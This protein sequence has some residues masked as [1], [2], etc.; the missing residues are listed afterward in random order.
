M[1]VGNLI[2]E[3]KS[4]TNF[5]DTLK[6]A[7]GSYGTN[8]IGQ[9][10]KLG[11]LKPLVHTYSQSFSENLQKGVEKAFNKVADRA[12]H[13]AVDYQ[14]NWHTKTVA[15][16]GESQRKDTYYSSNAYY[17]TLR[18][19]IYH[20]FSGLDTSNENAMKTDFENRLG[21]FASLT[22]VLDKAC[23]DNATARYVSDLRTLFNKVSEDASSYKKI[24]K[25]SVLWIKS[26]DACFFYN[27]FR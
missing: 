5:V 27:N 25:T 1:T 13:D 3:Q 6:L 20:L 17:G 10:A 22:E 9:F 19:D 11:M 18:E 24:N 8:D 7:V 16:F 21:K 26:Q 15:E 12:I 23:G 2:D 14:E 4:L